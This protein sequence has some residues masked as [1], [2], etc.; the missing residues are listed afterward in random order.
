MTN[1]FVLAAIAALV[2]GG[3]WLVRT[4]RA[5]HD[6]RTAFDVLT[7]K[8]PIGIM[9]ADEAGFCTFANDVWYELSGLD[10]GAALGH[11]WSQ[12]IHPD[13]V[14]MVMQRWEES[15]RLGVAY[16]N[17]VR[18][19]RPDGSIRTVMASAAPITD[20]VGHI[21]GF[22]GTVLDISG[23]RDAER[24]VREQTTLLQSFI[25]H[26]PAAIYV[27]DTAGRYLLINRRHADLWPAMRDGS[28]GTTPHAWF[29]E[30]IADSF[31]ETDRRVLESREALTFE[32]MLPHDDGPHSYVTVKFP[33]LD[34]VGRAVAVA[35]VSTDV[36]ELERARRA[37]AARE[38]LLRN[39]IEVQE[40]EKQTLCHEF[41]DG[42]IQYAVGSKMM[43]E[44][45][46]HTPLDDTTRPVV[47]SVI[48]YLAK[49]IEDG[50]RV[51]RGIRP[52][53][54]DD[55]GLEAA[56]CDLC[57]EVRSGGID[58]ACELDPAIDSLAAPLQ[59][60]IYRFVQESLA[61]V[62]KHSGAE[63][64]TVRLARDDGT[65]VVAVEDT[66][67]G[68]ASVHSDVSHAPDFEGGL[69]L[70]GMRERVRLAGGTCVIDSE[71]GSGTRICAILPIEARVTDAVTAR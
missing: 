37:L 44:S 22:I 50:R 69:G 62:R 30:A 9:V 57:E 31:V 33:V 39:L 48:D 64:A 71:P 24:R 70:L 1:L 27:K 17:E 61:N 49:G 38:R 4:R 67:C 46:K 2:A 28:V 42:L 11:S 26:A 43:L 19:V 56:I 23:R 29:P 20:A 45:L 14:P 36:T 10:P 35:G 13:D 3:V 12:A 25:D 58:V 55:L 8:A 7:T 59:T 16:V 53:A 54:L 32:E 63:R 18:L 6:C 51:I 47:E 60:T 66:G 15:V 52:A 5:L 40:R 65:V 41:H 68:F 21:S 34:E